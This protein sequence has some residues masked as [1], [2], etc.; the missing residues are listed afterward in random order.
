M[1]D[2]PIEESVRRVGTGWF[3]DG[4]LRDRLLMVMKVKGGQFDQ[5]RRAVLVFK[6]HVAP[7][8]VENIFLTIHES[9]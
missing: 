6:L 5:K 8:K 7:A 9:A 3:D 4:R 1:R 2:C